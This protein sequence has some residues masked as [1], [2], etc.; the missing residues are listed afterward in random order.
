MQ[1]KFPWGEVT[2]VHTVGPHRIIEYVVGPEWDNAGD[3]EFQGTG[4]G[5]WDTLDGALL[6]SICHSV[7]PNDDRLPEYVLRLIGTKD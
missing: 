6:S 3:T 7:H 2:A 4:T 1:D 5:S